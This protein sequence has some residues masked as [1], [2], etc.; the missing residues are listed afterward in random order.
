MCFT[1]TACL[2]PCVIHYIVF[3]WLLSTYFSLQQTDRSGKDPQNHSFFC[4]HAKNMS[5]NSLGQLRTWLGV[6]KFNPHTWQRR[7]NTV[8]SW[9]DKLKQWR[10]P[11]NIYALRS[12]AL[13]RLGQP[14]RF[15][16]DRTDQCFQEC[17]GL[18][19]LFLAKVQQFQLTL[20]DRRV[21]C[22]SDSIRFPGLQT[23]LYA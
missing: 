4:C 8:P 12:S 13:F 11:E 19:N 9:W 20:S 16:M 7:C 1:A 3:E 2:Y 17:N 22:F 10:K 6:G 21:L 5:E 15:Y 23:I 18:R 14:L